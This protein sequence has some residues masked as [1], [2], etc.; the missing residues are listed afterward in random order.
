MDKQIA[1]NMFA[2]TKKIILI[3]LLIGA[4]FFCWQNKEIKA[5]SSTIVIS[6]IMIGQT[7]AAKN[8]FIELRNNTNNN[9]DLTGYSLKKKTGSGNESNLVSSSKFLGAIPPNGYFL[10]AYP[11]YQG[12]IN[13]DLAYSGSSYSISSDNTI[14]L[15]DS[16][17]NIIDKVGFGDV[18][19]FE[20][21]PAVNPD[22]GKS[23]VRKSNADTDNNFSDF[24]IQN[25]PNPQNSNQEESEPEEEGEIEDEQPEPEEEEQEEIISSPSVITTN[26]LGDIVIN[27]FVSDP[28]DEDVEWIELYNTTNKEIDLAGWIIEEGGEAKT[29]LEGIIGSSNESK[30]FVIEKPKGNLNNK[31]DIIILRNASGTLIDQ[32]VYGNWDDGNVN[33]NAPAASDP[34]SAARKFD[35][36]NSFNNANDFVVTVA[37][38]QGASNIIIEGV[39]DEEGLRAEKGNYDYSDDIVISEIFPNPEGSD[40]ET[41]FIELFNSGNRDVDLTGWMLGDLTSKKYEVGSKNLG[42]ENKNNSV[43]IKAGGYLTVY[44]SESKIALNNGG[45]SVK[46]FRPL[47]DVVFQVV[48]YDK[49]VENWSYNLNYES[50]RSAGQVGIM[51]Y[52]YLWS[53]TVT[54]GEENIVEKINHEPIVEFDCP[55]EILIG[56]PFLFDGS[57][58]MD[59]DEDDLIYEWDFG[60]GFKNNLICPEHTFFQAGAYTVKLTVSDGENEIVKEKIV[61]ATSPLTPLLA[62]ERGINI[63]P[64]PYEGEGRGEVIINEFLPNPEGSDTEGE[65]I[66]IKNKG[67]IKINLLDWKLDDNIDGSN[68]YKF[69]EDVWLNGGMFL[70]VARSESGLALNND[71]DSV[72]LLDNFDELI[73]EIKYEQAVEGR[74]YA[75]GQNGKWFWTAA[76]TPGE[77]NII[78]VSGSE[79]LGINNYESGEAGIEPGI[80]ETTL[81]EIRQLEPGD[82]VKVSGTVAVKPGILGSQYFYIVGS[83]GVQV[84]SYNKEFPDLE[85]GDYIEVQG[86]LSAGSGEP[87]IKTKTLEDIKIIERRDP[88]E[89]GELTCENINE[90]SVGRLVSITGEVVE[91]KSSVV[92]LDDGTGEAIVYIKA[93]TGISPASIKEGDMV[94]IAGIV[95]RT[96]SGLRVM[97]RSNDDIIKKDVEAAGRASQ[98]FGE[99]PASGEWGISARDKKLELFKYLLVIAAG[100]IIVLA[101][102][103][104]K[105][106]RKA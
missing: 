4:G 53:E 103:L 95:G 29:T 99:V 100:A 34:Y 63:A 26:K 97:P 45:D 87:R 35:G 18:V 25:S 31:G 88:P 6:E 77:E 33:N 64:S 9:I 17:G 54:P 58:T 62:N 46:L 69:A 8:E 71:F 15:Y 105:E 84:Y 47:E 73:D 94:K 61:K 98:V 56:V 27:E 52:E 106:A 68:P 89:A 14:I 76:L 30:F 59:Q 66:E 101:G 67:E 93:A 65:W 1:G 24:E 72:R 36:Q 48:D 85:I 32:V 7:E 50:P 60:D 79:V 19:D 51:N 40:N 21:Q 41:E 11:A 44:R 86:E 2:R 70:S 38:T 12:E 90:D 23:I 42:D 10:I 82:M 43:V 75:R 78:S 39:E 28:A 102:L 83:P 49:A 13:A 92:Y 96:A 80:I 55:E 104:I 37:P 91:R 3:L 57:D 22:A 74:S 5:V 81:E 20:G 16:N